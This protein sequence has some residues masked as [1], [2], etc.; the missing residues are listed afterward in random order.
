MGAIVVAMHAMAG[1][2]Q[3][4]RENNMEVAS[5]KESGAALFDWGALIA[6]IGGLVLGLFIAAKAVD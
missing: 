1:L 2:R 3:D 5:T 4:L 6:A